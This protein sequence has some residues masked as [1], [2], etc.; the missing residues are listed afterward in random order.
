MTQTFQSEGSKEE[1]DKSNK[2]QQKD[3]KERRKKQEKK[4]VEVN[5]EQK[6]EMFKLKR[7]QKVQA[8]VDCYR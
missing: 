4:K 2:T 8:I 1:L 6:K 5:Q 7:F 3:G